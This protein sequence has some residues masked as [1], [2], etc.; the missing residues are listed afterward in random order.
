GSFPSA[1]NN[2]FSDSTPANITTIGSDKTGR[3]PLLAAISATDGDDVPT[4]ALGTGSPA[5]DA[6]SNVV[7]GAPDNLTTDARGTGFARKSGTLVD[8]GAYEFQDPAQSGPNFVVNKVGDSGAGGCTEFDCTLREAITAA[9]ELSGADTISFTLPVANQMNGR[10]TITPTSSLPAITDGVT[11]DGTST[12][13]LSGSS[14]VGANISGLTVASSGSTIKGLHFSGWSG[15]A[16][17]VNSGN[18]NNLRGNTFSG[19]TGI[20][21]NL[22]GGTE[23]SNGVTANDAGDIDSGANNLQNSPLLPKARTPQGAAGT[24]VEG[25]LQGQTGV[26]YT[27]DFYSNPAA[28]ASGY[29]EGA[30]PIGTTTVSVRSN[31]VTSFVATLPVQPVGS[32]ITAIATDAGGN[33]SEFSNGTVNSDDVT[34]PTVTITTP[35]N[36]GSVSSLG[37][38]A[39]NATD[40]G[41]SV[42]RVE[43]VLRYKDSSGV[44]QYWAQ[45]NGSWSWGSDVLAIPA[46]LTDS[47]A[48]STG[49]S[50]SNGSPSGTVLP[51]GTNLPARTYYLLAYAYDAAGNKTRSATPDTAFVVTAPIA[52]GVTVTSPSSG[53]TV[54]SLATIEGEAVAG[55]GVAR[56]EAFLRYKNSSGVFQYWAKRN[57]TWSW[58]SDILAIPAT[59]TNAGA[60]ST[61]WS[62]SNGSPSGTVLPSGAN[63]PARTYYLLAYVYDTAGNKARS[64]TPDATFKV[65]A[66]V[67]PAV[68]VTS[69]RSGTTVQSLALIE[70]EA[71]AGNS[72]ARVDA[73]LRYKNSSGIFQYWAKR[74]GT[75]GWGSDILGIPASLT[76]AGANST[77]W[78]ISN[79]SPE[80]T[81][82]PS[83]A[84][85]PARTYYVLAYVYDPAGARTRSVAPDTSFKV[86][87][88]NVPFLTQREAQ[89]SAVVLSSA[90]ATAGGSITLTFTGALDAAKAVEASRYSVQQNG[91]ELEIASASYNATS[92]TVTLTLEAA[93]AAGS[94]EVSY[95]LTDSKGLSLTG[96]TTF[97][98]K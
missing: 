81:V 90:S 70:G 77:G 35:A 6:G 69:P 12:V 17:R 25:K 79:D 58:A 11:I 30:T 63:L 4:M 89:K 19:N 78:S 59:L 24:T 94:V 72:V 96:Q 5:I 15:N 14:A 73:F 50:I 86:E 53:S 49:W 8:I 65:E 20:S 28:H 21:I 91:V 51:S 95:E 71:V 48:A 56:V 16:I 57:G 74:S 88:P 38:I 83:G 54:Q 3:D 84:N 32:V 40:V 98:I 46:T 93:P 62:V 2:L 87:V 64:A 44:F 27:I 9:N 47:G 34:G 43:A 42:V 80:G 82:L 52:P 22:V 13:I 36:G 26:T 33:S 10:W 85:L 66:T 23:D 7:L 41:G 76:N 31:N 68:T 97:G 39:G 60:V 29:G 37:S 92:H 75:W 1:G 67:A 55:N 18:N 45:R 61:G